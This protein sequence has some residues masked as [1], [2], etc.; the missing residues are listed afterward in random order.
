MKPG[1]EPRLATLGTVFQF[2]KHSTWVGELRW[3]FRTEF[4]KLVTV[5]LAKRVQT[6]VKIACFVT[7]AKIASTPV[8]GNTQQ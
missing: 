4:I 1:Q 7:W 2:E 6:N 8:V 3:S 5:K